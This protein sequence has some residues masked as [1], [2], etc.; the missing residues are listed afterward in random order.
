M[1]VAVTLPFS[2]DV[3]AKM[4][5][6]GIESEI[7]DASSSTPTLS[8]LQS[9]SS[10]FVWND[11]PFSNRTALSDVLAEYVDAGGH[12]VVAM[13]SCSG[14]PAYESSRLIGGRFDGMHPIPTSDYT[15]GD[16]AFL[17]MSISDHPLMLNV[18]SFDGGVASF[19]PLQKHVTPGATLVASWLGGEPLVAT[20][21]QTFNGTVVSLGMWP[22]SS[23]FAGGYWNVSSSGAQLIANAVNYRPIRALGK[24]CVP[25]K[26][27]CKSGHCVGGVCD[28]ALTTA[29]HSASVVSSS[30]M[31]ASATTTVTLDPIDSLSSTPSVVVSEATRSVNRTGG[32]CCSSSRRHFCR[33]AIGV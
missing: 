10:V 7:F 13:F 9:S 20:F 2:N 12:V 18:T 33:C 24:P 15:A 23:D 31:R 30:A 16:R 21:D 22:P 27:L 6:K 3:A 26:T 11:R 29:T 25:G 8:R 1:V 14:T 19:R 28:S 32:W 5:S 17:G 4:L